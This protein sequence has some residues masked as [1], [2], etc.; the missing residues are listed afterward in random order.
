M[1]VEIIHSW[2]D[3]PK[4]KTSVLGDPEFFDEL[5]EEAER[6]EPV[7]ARHVEIAQID[8]DGESYCLRILDLDNEF[9]VTVVQPSLDE[10]TVWQLRRMR[11]QKTD[12]VTWFHPDDPFDESPPSS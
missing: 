8:D 2:D 11:D 4:P 3:E 9:R 5:E 6:T 10:T 1:L 12:G 7:F